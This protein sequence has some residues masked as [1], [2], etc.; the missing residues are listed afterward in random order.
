[1]RHFDY[2]LA[3]K[4]TKALPK[5]TFPRK[6]EKNLT[7]LH[8]SN[9]KREITVLPVKSI[10]DYEKSI[11]VHDVSQYRKEYFILTLVP[12]IEVPLDFLILKCNKRE[13]PQL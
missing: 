8:M 1:M 2:V 4:P 9:C 5:K 3:M 12:K 7:V 11:P 6:V 10:A 13:L